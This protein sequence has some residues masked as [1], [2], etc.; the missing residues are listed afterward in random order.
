MTQDTSTGVNQ[1]VVHH[2]AESQNQTPSFKEF[3]PGNV[4]DDSDAVAFPHGRETSGY[5]GSGNIPAPD[6]GN[7]SYP[8]LP[9]V[10][11]E[12]GSSFSEGIKL[13]IIS[14]IVSILE[15]HLTISHRGAPG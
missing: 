2:S 6:D 1:G 13:S 9:P 14:K 4:V 10:L 3:T 8:Y 15:C 12:P 7:S 11:E 5:W